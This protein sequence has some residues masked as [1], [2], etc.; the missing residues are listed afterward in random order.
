MNLENLNRMNYC[1]APSPSDF[2]S[3]QGSASARSEP[4]A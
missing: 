1:G 4:N 2:M 3:A